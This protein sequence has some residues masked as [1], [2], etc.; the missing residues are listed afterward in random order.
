[1]GKSFRKKYNRLKW[2]GGL[3]IFTII[4]LGLVSWLISVRL[5]PILTSELKSLVL[6]ST[7][8]LYHVEFSD[9]KTNILTGNAALMNVK[10][11]PDTVILNKLIALKRAPNNIYNIQLK[12]LMVRGFHPLKLWREHKLN[13]DLLRFDKPTVV[14]TNKQLDF[15]ENKPPRPSKSPYLY[16]AAHL[17]ELRVQTIAFRD[18]KF[19]YVNSNLQKPEVDEVKNMNVTLTDWL[20]D[21]NS[22]NDR[23]RLYL[24]KDIALS[25]N[26]Y[27]YATPDSLYQ[28]NINQ[29]N[30]RASTGRVSIKMFSLNPRYDEMEFGKKAGYQKER[31][32]IQ[33][34][35]MSLDG[36]NFPLYVLKQELFAEKMDITNGFVAVFNNNA[37][38]VRNEEKN[39]KY[40]HQLFQNVKELI[41]VQKLNLQNINLSYAE[42]DRN[43]QQ[44]GIIT[45]DNTSG[46]IT[47]VTNSPKYKDKNA[48]MEA[49]LS[50]YMMGRGRLT[51]NF[52]FDLKAKDGAFTY[53]GSLTNMT[54]RSLNKI[55]KPLGMV[56]I[57]SGYV[58]K[59]MFDIKANEHLATG[60][61]DFSYQDLSVGLFKK[62]EGKDN[63]VKQGWASFLVNQLVINANNPDRDG[64]FSSAMVHYERQPAASFF[65]F[66]WHTLFQ[67]IKYSIG[68]TEEKTAKISGQIAQFQKIKT[69]RDLRRKLRQRRKEQEIK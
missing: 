52:R 35:D 38:P 66:I 60:R 61:V 18:I 44:K 8:S 25:V 13:V 41:T 23:S 56:Q 30:F 1:M 32:H 62:V 24:L 10:I 40:P 51:T 29:L 55:T 15:N 57:K 47:N 17:K 39:G 27:T 26:D 12:R 65:N 48:L 53:T 54:G 50:S 33:M 69:D 67:G 22:A 46:T 20:I 7:D 19:T 4:V 21:P 31:Y 28:I 49:N 43:S 42:F 9:I 16:I 5:K 45:F 59:L 36:I 64:K 34:S 11:I 58:N 37:L 6:R 68:L 63:L 3:I 2:I 14:M